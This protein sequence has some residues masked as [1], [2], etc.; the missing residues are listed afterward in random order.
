VTL[1]RPVGI[2]ELRLIA[3]SGYTAFPPR[4]PDQPIFY[5]VLN[6]EY[7]EQIAKRWNAKYNAV[8]CGFVTRFEVDDDYLRRFEIQTV[9]GQVHQEFWIPAEEL[10]EFNRNIVGAI[11]VEAAYYG[12]GFSGPVDAETNLPVGLGSDPAT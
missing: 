10:E 2:E 9:G 8:A 1:Y 6:F 5:P 3:S 7:A 4:L 12:E 11:S